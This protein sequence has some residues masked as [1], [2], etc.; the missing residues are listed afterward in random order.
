M[1][2]SKCNKEGLVLHTKVEWDTGKVV[3][4]CV[5][6]EVASTPELL[7]SEEAEDIIAELRDTRDRVQRLISASGSSSLD[8]ETPAGAISPNMLLAA[9]HQFLR[10]AEQD[11]DNI[12]AADS[13]DPNPPAP[14]DDG[15]GEKPDS[16]P[17]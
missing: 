16:D 9:V 4:T 1:K 8:E 13:N 12:L 11:R 3:R 5:D 7:C 17:R 2:C 6:C 14:P 15:Y 10:N